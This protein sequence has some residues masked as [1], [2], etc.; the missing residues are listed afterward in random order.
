MKGIVK[1]SKLF[2]LFTTFFLGLCEFN[3]MHALSKVHANGNT[4][5]ENVITNVKYAENIRFYYTITVPSNGYLTFETKE[6]NDTV[7]KLYNTSNKLVD[8]A[9]VTKNS[10]YKTT[11]SV[12]KGSYKLETYSTKASDYSFCYDF[13]TDTQLISGKKITIY[14]ASKKQTIYYK[15]K[16]NK[17]GYISLL[18]KNASCYITLCD[19]TKKALSSKDYINSSIPDYN[20]VVYG[21]K[22]GATYYVKL[23]SFDPKIA[24][25]YAF[26]S[27]NDRSGYKKSKAYKLKSGK[28]TT[29]LIVANKGTVDWY[30]FKLS[31]PKKI[32]ITFSGST[33]DQLYIQIYNSRGESILYS[34]NYVY[35]AN[36][37]RTIASMNNLKA[38]TYYIKI[39]RG[40]SKS[41]G[42]YNL[43][44]K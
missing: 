27:V 42:Y 9:T 3:F 44:F 35:G 25:R 32:T 39:T 4:L 41:S 20:K 15:V 13:S 6:A 43:K 21:I 22:K 1:I 26:T 31:A 29:G 30:K 38:E 2:I 33:N 40:N 23:N 36:F 14:P 5:K 18:T 24:L 16:S 8:Y 28:K 17:T 11:F 12:K 7:Y 37:K 19:K 10:D 34:S